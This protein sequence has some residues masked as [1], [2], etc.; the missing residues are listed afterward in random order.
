[1]P[2]V[3]AQHVNAQVV[4]IPFRQ[5]RDIGR[6]L[7]LLGIGPAFLQQLLQQFFPFESLLG[8]FSRDPI[9]P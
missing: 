7:T 3:T 5:F 8:L 2:P 6:Y 1:M 9:A 4:P